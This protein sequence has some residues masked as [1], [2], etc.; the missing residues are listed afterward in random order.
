MKISFEKFCN[1]IL[2]RVSHILAD[3]GIEGV[4]LVRRNKLNDQ[5]LIGITAEPSKIPGFE[6]EMQAPIVYLNAPYDAYVRDN[7]VTLDDLSLQI[8][9]GYL[10]AFRPTGFMGKLRNLEWKN[11]K[12]H[13]LP[14]IVCT[15]MNEAYLKGRP[16]RE[17][18]GTDLAS[19]YYILFEKNAEGQYSSPVTDDMMKAWGI[20]VDELHETAVENVN[21]NIEFK[22]VADIMAELLRHQLKDMGFSEESMDLRVENFY[23]DIEEQDVNMFVLRSSKLYGAAA[24]LSKDAMDKVCDKV[25]ETYRVLPASVHELIILPDDADIPDSDVRNI[26]GAVNEDE[27]LPEER[28]SY[29]IYRYTRGKGLSL[30]AAVE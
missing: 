5:V 9:D 30:I 25:G 29:N 24:M 13:V 26:V 28:L 3:E 27:L 8:A 12:S 17:I 20:E 23:E 11:V 4:T 7:T 10:R 14:K 6:T 15:K 2:S 22:K 18:P 1:E 16:Y 19:T 21:S